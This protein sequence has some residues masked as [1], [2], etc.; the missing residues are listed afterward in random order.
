MN[1]NRTEQIRWQEWILAK[2]L[3]VSIKSLCPSYRELSRKHK[4]NE[5]IRENSRDQRKEIPV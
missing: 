1:S 4:K 5:R 3:H 2:S